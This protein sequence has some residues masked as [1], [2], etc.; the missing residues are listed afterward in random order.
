MLRFLLIFTAI[1]ATPAFGTVVECPLVDPDNPQHVLVGAEGVSGAQSHS[2]IQRRGDIWQETEITEQWHERDVNLTCSYRG[3]QGGG[4]AIILKVPGLMLRCDY[5]AQD[6]L[7]PQPAEP[8]TG[9]PTEVRFLR[10]W[11]TSR[12]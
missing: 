1:L 8:G 10:V 5:L 12:P 7:K 3:P 4:R 6:V 2:T 11:C 9:G